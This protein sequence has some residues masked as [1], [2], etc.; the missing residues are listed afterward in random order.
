METALIIDSN[1]IS[2]FQL[3]G[4][5]L[6]EVIILTTAAGDS[7]TYSALGLFDTGSETTQPDGN[8]PSDPENPDAPPAEEKSGGAGDPATG[9]QEETNEKRSLF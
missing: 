2:V 1:R 9:N 6:P 5:Q 8:P 7:V 4:N 3:P